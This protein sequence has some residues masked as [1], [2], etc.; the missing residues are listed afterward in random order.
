MRTD[1]LTVAL[2][3]QPRAVG[4]G[5][6]TVGGLLQFI[7]GHDAGSLWLRARGFELLN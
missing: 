2:G 4:S 1:Y 5:A 3:A 7:G 6:S